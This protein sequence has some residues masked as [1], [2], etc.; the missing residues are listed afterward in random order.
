VYEKSLL[1][2]TAFVLD[3]GLRHAACGAVW[4]GLQ[5]GVDLGHSTFQISNSS[6]VMALIRAVVGNVMRSN[7]VPAVLKLDFLSLRITW[8]FAAQAPSMHLVT[9]GVHGNRESLNEVSAPE[10]PTAQGPATNGPLDFVS[11]RPV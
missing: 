11:K 8:Y 10:Q 4:L 5:E 3:S 7:S 9:H 1:Q 6:S 2:R